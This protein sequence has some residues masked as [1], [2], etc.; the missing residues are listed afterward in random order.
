MLQVVSFWGQGRQDTISQAQQS[1][2]AWLQKNKNVEV[3]NV[4]TTS[5]IGMVSSSSV[6]RTFIITFLYVRNN[7]LAR[8]FTLFTQL[9]TEPRGYGEV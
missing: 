7:Q 5:D 8:R 1:A 9:P 3:V 6:D 4:S 2:N